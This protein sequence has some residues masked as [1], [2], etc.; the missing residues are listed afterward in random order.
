MTS[1]KNA[2]RKPDQVQLNS[3][4]RQDKCPP[5]SMRELVTGQCPRL[6]GEG[7]E[8]GEFPL[9]RPGKCRL[10]APST[11]A[12]DRLAEP[13]LVAFV[14]PRSALLRVEETWRQEERTTVLTRKWKHWQAVNSKS[15]RGRRTVCVPR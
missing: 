11:A 8:T 10:R 1:F 9:R 5:V 13:R 12:R 15:T 2:M 3:V 14:L 4:Y 7:Q 6:G